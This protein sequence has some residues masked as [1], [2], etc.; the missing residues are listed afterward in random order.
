MSN[1][2]G[3]DWHKQ[4]HSD[5]HKD[6]VTLGHA[7]HKI[8]RYYDKLLEQKDPERLEQIKEKR[9]QA[10]KQ[11]VKTEHKLEQENTIAHNNFKRKNHRTL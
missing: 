5:T 11:N 9:I 6:Y 3:K 1:G 4:Y 2:I 10:A 7:K 8:P